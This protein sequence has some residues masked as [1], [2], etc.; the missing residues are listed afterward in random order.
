MQQW[1]GQLRWAGL[2]RV[3]VGGAPELLPLEPNRPEA[4]LEEL[5]LPPPLLRDPWLGVGKA[6][7]C[8]L[9]CQAE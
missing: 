4:R 2:A 5:H 3:V 6:A 1:K 9:I 8:P 7:G